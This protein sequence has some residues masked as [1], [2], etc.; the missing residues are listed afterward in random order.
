MLQ[1]LAAL[2]AVHKYGHIPDQDHGVQACI[3]RHTGQPV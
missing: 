2:Q 1:L 3:R